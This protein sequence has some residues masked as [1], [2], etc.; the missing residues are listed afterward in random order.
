MIL[1]VAPDPRQLMDDRDANLVQMFG[2]PD[3]GEFI[4]AP[5]RFEA[6]SGIGADRVTA[7]LL[8]HL[9]R[10]PISRRTLFGSAAERGGE[11]NEAV[12]DQFATARKPRKLPRDHGPYL[13]Q[14]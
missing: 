7:L 6:L 2:R 11:V 12:G 1:Q 13:R 9:A 4:A 14:R 5:Y 8:E 10:H 3:T